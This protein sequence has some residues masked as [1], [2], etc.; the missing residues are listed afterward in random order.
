MYYCYL[1]IYKHKINTLLYSKHNIP[2][3]I[4]QSKLRT[5]ALALSSIIFLP[6]SLVGCLQLPLPES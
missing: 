4:S 5:Q 3:K 2:D 6:Q 1:L